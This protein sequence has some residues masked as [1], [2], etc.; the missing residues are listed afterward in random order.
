MLATAA[1][2]VQTALTSLGGAIA[3]TAS[4]E[5]GSFLVKTAGLSGDKTLGDKG[6]EF[7][8]RAAVSSMMFG[9]SS[10][11]MPET[12]QNVL[13][14]FI[15]FASDA[16]LIGTARDIGALIVTGLSKSS[17]LVRTPLYSAKPQPRASSACCGAAPG[18]AC[19]CH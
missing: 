12:S 3:G 10:N 1:A 8:I 19:T 9:I 11:Y 17:A 15:Y 6:L 5:L 7:V 18:A 13:F 16:K 4:S 2:D 14:T